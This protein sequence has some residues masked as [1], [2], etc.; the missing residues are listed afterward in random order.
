MGFGERPSS[1]TNKKRIVPAC[2]F[3]LPSRPRA[4]TTMG[5][6]RGVA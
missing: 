4:G 2:S 1:M 3:M 5:V 6:A